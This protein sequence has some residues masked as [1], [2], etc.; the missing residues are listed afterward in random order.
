LS[1]PNVRTPD[2]KGYRDVRAFMEQDARRR[3]EREL[4]PIVRREHDGVAAL[5]V[6][7]GRARDE[8]SDETDPHKAR[9]KP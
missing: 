7:N 6:D 9:K 1:K 3:A 5:R 4:L 8:S 2:D